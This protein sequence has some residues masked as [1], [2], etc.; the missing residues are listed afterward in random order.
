[1]LVV[2]LVEVADA[3]DPA[4]HVDRDGRDV[5][6]TK[7]A[8][9]AG[10]AHRGGEEPSEEGVL[11][12]VVEQRV[13]V[14]DRRRV[15]VVDDREV[16]VRVGFRRVLGIGS[17]Q[18]ADRDDDAAVQPDERLDV[19]LVV[20]RRGRRQVLD[21]HRRVHKLGILEAL[22]SRSVEGTVVDPTGVG[23]LAGE[24]RALVAHRRGR[25]V[26]RRRGCRGGPGRGHA[27]DECQRR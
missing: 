1:M 15:A 20:A 8:D 19:R 2:D 17:H 21:P 18:E 25:T 12:R 27:R 24:E 16:L 9:I 10:R 26:A 23:H 6:T 3:G 13:D 22:P 11:V 5:L 7:R 14:L 4:V